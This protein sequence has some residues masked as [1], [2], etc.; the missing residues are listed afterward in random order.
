MCDAINVGFAD[1]EDLTGAF[2]GDNGIGEI[3]G[4]AD[5]GKD[6]GLLLGA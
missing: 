2:T 4:E 5:V 6:T 1:D 3:V